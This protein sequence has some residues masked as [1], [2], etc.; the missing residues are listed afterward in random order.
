MLEILCWRID[1][2]FSDCVKRFMVP[3]PDTRQY[4]FAHLFDLKF[5]V[6]LKKEINEKEDCD[7]PLNIK[8]IHHSLATTVVKMVLGI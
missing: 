5:A 6:F 8:L 4:I 7:G 1:P 3:A 2:L